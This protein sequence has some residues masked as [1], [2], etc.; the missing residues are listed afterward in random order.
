MGHDGDVPASHFLDVSQELNQR[1][2]VGI[3]GKAL[4]PKS[5]CARANSQILDV[6]EVV[7]VLERFQVLLEPV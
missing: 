4:R 6:R 5:K 2:R 3:G 7:G 1:V